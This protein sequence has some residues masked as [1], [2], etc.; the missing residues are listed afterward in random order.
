MIINSWGAGSSNSADVSGDGVVNLDDL[1]MVV[2]AW[3][4]CE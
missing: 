1:L 2:N 4:P 3:G